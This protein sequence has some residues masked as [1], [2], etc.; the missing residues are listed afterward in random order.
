MATLR[1]DIAEQIFSLSLAS[2][3]LYIRSDNDRVDFDAFI[4]Y[5]HR[6]HHV[7]QI[8]SDSGF[9]GSVL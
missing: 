3:Y 6:L 8:L 1:K 2:K 9:N 5:V 7:F 4:S